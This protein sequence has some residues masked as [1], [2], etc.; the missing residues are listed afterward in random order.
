[1]TPAAP[2][3]PILTVDLEEWFHLL[4]CKEVC[5]AAQWLGLESRIVQNTHRLLDLFDQH[6]VKASFFVLGWVAEHYPALIR[7]IQA[8]GHEIGCHSHW[9][10]LVWTQTPAAFRQETLRALNTLADTTGQP[11]QM[12]RAPGFSIRADCLWAFEIL[13][14]LGITLDA[15]VFPGR[16]AHGGVGHRYPA[17]P[18]RLETPSGPLL[19]FPMSL[20]RVGPLDFAYAGG[21]YFRLLPWPAIRRYIKSNSYNMTYFHPRDFDPE[22]PRIPELAFLRSMRAYLGLSNSFGK[23]ETL[24]SAFPVV[25]IGQANF[26]F[27]DDRPSYSI[28]IR[29]MP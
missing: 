9:H 5:E 14:E 25:P 16:H 15:S 4:D 27:I 19:E 20:A 13:A 29:A 8:R 3:A 18:F 7:Q 6:S 10:T 11:I 24:L 2:S 21:G 12:Y 17:T 26:Y 23:L 22:Q 1:M 28:S